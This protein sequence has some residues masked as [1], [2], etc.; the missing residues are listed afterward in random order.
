MK[1]VMGRFSVPF[2][3]RIHGISSARRRFEIIDGKL[4]SMACNEREASPLFRYV[5]GN[6]AFFIAISETA[7]TVLQDFLINDRIPPLAP[8]KTLLFTI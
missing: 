6:R 1:S 5:S 7:P 3:D 4:I 8:G 2:R